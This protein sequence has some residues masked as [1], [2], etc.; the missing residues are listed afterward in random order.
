[1]T[2]N[3]NLS[4]GRG[5]ESVKVDTGE[6]KGG[7]KREELSSEKLKN[8]FD[9]YDKDGNK[10]LSTEE[11]QAFVQEVKTA[12]G[13]SVFSKK[14]AG[15]YIKNAGIENSELSADDVYQFTTALVENS[16]NK[17]VLNSVADENGNE[18]IE[19]KNNKEETIGKDGTNI[20]KTVDEYGTV[21]TETTNSNGSKVIKYQEENG[22]VTSEHQDTNG[23]LLKKEY[24]AADGSSVVEQYGMSGGKNILLKEEVVEKGGVA[25]TVIEHGANGP[26]SKV[27][28]NGALTTR[29]G[30]SEDGMEVKE[31]ETQKLGNGVVKTTTYQ[32]QPD[33]SDKVVVKQDGAPTVTTIKTPGANS[34]QII[35]DENFKTENTLGENGSKLNQIKT[36]G[37]NQYTAEYDGNGNTKVV[38]QDG[39]SISSMKKN[40][41]M[42]DKQ[43][44]EFLKMNKSQLMGKEPNQYFKVGAQILIPGEF[45]SDDKRLATRV[46]A[47]EAKS[48]YEA[49]EKARVQERLEG[50]QVQVKD[51]VVDKD[52]KNW[53]SYSEDMLKKEGNANPTKQQIADRMNE[54]QNLNEGVQ[55]PKKDT[56]IKV[57]MTTQEVQEIATA[58]KAADAKKR[59]D[60]KAIATEL[61]NIADNNIGGVSLRKMQ[62]VLDEKVTAD[63][64]VAILDSYKGTVSDNETLVET[65]CSEQSGSA[66]Q[67][68]AL[69][70]VLNKM[71]EAAKKAGV[72]Q[73]D[74]DFAKTHFLQ[75]MKNEHSAAHATNTN[76]ME[77]S[78]DFLRGAIAAKKQG[79]DVPEINTKEAME[80]FING[81]TVLDE[82]GAEVKEGGFTKFNAD[83]QKD[84]K[85]ARDGEGWIAWTG[86]KVCGLFGCVTVEDMDKKLG[87]NAAGAKKLAAAAESG[88]EVEFKKV[89]KEV[90][91]IEFDA[92]KIEAR[93][94][95]SNKLVAARGLETAVKQY[96]VILKDAQNQDL[97]ALRNSVKK[98]LN[99]DEQAKA[100]S[101]KSGKKMT[102]DDLIDEIF[103]NY[104]STGQTLTDAEKKDALISAMKQLKANSSDSLNKMTGGKTFD[105]M[106]E[107]LD[108]L[109][110]A[111]YGTNDIAKDVTRFNENQ[112]LTE[113]YA[114]MALDIAGT[115]ALNA[116]LP[117]IGTAITAARVAKMGAS[118][119]K[120]M[121]A[122][123]KVK[124]VVKTSKTVKTA[125]T[126]INSTKKG[127]YIADVAL[128]SLPHVRNAGVATAVIHGTNNEEA[129]D[130][131]KRTLMN[132]SFAGVGAGGS[133]VARD[134]AAKLAPQLAS[135]GINIGEKV[136]AEIIE[137]A[138]NVVGSAAVTTGFGDEYNTNNLMIDAVT[139]SIMARISHVKGPQ[140]PA[141]ETHVVKELP[142]PPVVKKT[143]LDV[144]TND[145]A[146]VPGGK[147]GKEKLEVAKAEIKAEIEHGVT[148]ERQA[149]INQEARNLQQQSR[150][151]GREISHI[152]EDGTG[153]YISKKGDIDLGVETDIA[154]LQDFKAE[155]GTWKDSGRDVDGIL[156][157]ID[158][159][160][161]YLNEHPEIQ[162]PSTFTDSEILTANRE[163]LKKHVDGFLEGKG[164]LGP[165]SKAF[166]AEYIR[167]T[168]NLDDLVK[169]E[170]QLKNKELT[171]GGRT[172][173]YN[174]LRSEIAARRKA[175]A[176]KVEIGKAEVTEMLA[177]KK[178]VGKGMN[179]DE[180]KQVKE[181]LSKVTDEADLKEIKAL[182]NGQKM[183]SSQK[184]QLK[185][186]LKA[187]E[188]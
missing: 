31:S 126:A 50:R 104:T 177:N 65:I 188:S 51:S 180:F 43:F 56:K 101:E 123:N 21:K 70:A 162:K 55:I 185:E 100:Y 41:G 186:L 141:P 37:Q 105:Q 117:G 69:E 75:S 164:Q 76:E 73:N 54:L 142:P 33:G 103:K 120:V 182:L 124:T 30:Y 181:Y 29:Y 144:A 58:Q 22:A 172:E 48:S 159:R 23:N 93:E 149:Q 168:D 91:G 44:S 121:N 127:K 139:G 90:F 34:K 113:A 64:I 187:K 63:N 175:L 115:I 19:Y 47:D 145:G 140:K 155:V 78:L 7:I 96:E 150:D 87:A 18:I 4:L 161:K 39:E 8:I 84:Y 92:Q 102:G 68:K 165:H 88:N 3:G 17:G 1:M 99:L 27:V 82:A 9:K 74:I 71:S 85:T 14:E 80:R 45:E 16:K 2:G 52:Y 152:V 5:K 12:A 179:P 35:E 66:P 135:K 86:D 134:I 173:Y 146:S 40:F 119:V 110:K 122:M 32:K 13:N 125:T 163:Q 28:E 147:L 38:V 129:E 97:K 11:S 107:D 143:V 118:A 77:K 36:V 72:S 184:S 167:K 61:Y 20:I 46:S 176:P 57:P 111:A 53:W 67:K 15:K 132:M 138:N 128:K 79:K 131:V 114:G 26:K 137:D 95:A 183:T 24:I 81:N 169:I 171:R 62:K 133:I 112:Q 156:A 153:V 109:T 160:M 151:Q 60:A 83:A 130:V 154:K 10:V 6:V 158:E 59:T 170:A 116:L 89:Y 136:L 106:E 166:T 174:E 98:N 25:K 178:A 148:P 108:I 42:N 94:E 157:K 49:G